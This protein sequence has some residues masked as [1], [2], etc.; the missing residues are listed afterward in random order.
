VATGAIVFAGAGLAA[1]ATGTCRAGTVFTAARALASLALCAGGGSGAPS[2]TGNIGSN[3]SPS[4]I[5]N[6]AAS[7]IPRSTN[8]S[9]S[10]SS[11]ARSR[12]TSSSLPPMRPA[13]S[14]ATSKPARG[15]RSECSD[16][17][18]SHRSTR[19]KIV[20]QISQS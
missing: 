10:A 9:T 18:P 13:P 1:A 4:R 5:S 6:V 19:N 11:A 12:A 17:C 2:A 15:V 7:T 14:A 20:E 16:I 3:R 8:S